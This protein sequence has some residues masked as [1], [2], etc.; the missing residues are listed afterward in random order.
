MC[1]T[2][3]KQ[4]KNLST[5]VKFLS[6]SNVWILYELCRALTLLA[7]LFILYRR[8]IWVY[9]NT[10]LTRF[11]QALNQS[12]VWNYKF[13]LLILREKI[14]SG[15]IFHVLLH[16]GSYIVKKVDGYFLDD[17]TISILTWGKDW[18]LLIHM[19]IPCIL[20]YIVSGCLY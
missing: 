5:V 10:L 11:I 4:P 17:I 19:Y 14:I 15:F 3:T 7:S 8:K 13:Y 1:I 20:N 18:Y 12:A 6:F 16:C 9:S 2:H